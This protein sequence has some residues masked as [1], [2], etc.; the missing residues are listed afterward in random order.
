MLV[1]TRQLFDMLFAESSKFGAIGYSK[2]GPTSNELT[3]SVACYLSYAIVGEALDFS[4]SRGI[5]LIKSFY[6][7]SPTE[8]VVCGSVAVSRLRCTDSRYKPRYN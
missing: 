3:A 1:S 6:R 8:G 7:Y 4:G 5:S 2:V